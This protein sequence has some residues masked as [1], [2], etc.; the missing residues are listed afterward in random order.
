[1]TFADIGANQGELTLIAA[2]SLSSGTVL[3]FEPMPN[4]FAKLAHNVELNGFSNVR[5][6]NMGLFDSES[7]LPMY[8]KNDS[9]FGAVNEG[10]PSLFS[11]GSDRKEVSVPLRRFD[12]VAR[13]SGLTRLDVMKIDVEGAEMMALRGAEGSIRQFRPVIIIEISEVN[14]RNAGYS[15][16]DLVV[17]LKSL[18]YDIRSLDDRTG[19]LASQCDAVCFPH[20]RAGKHSE[21]R[22]GSPPVPAL[23]V[24]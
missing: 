7:S 17:Y 24:D 10:V 2:K 3:A 9:A 19:A 23:Q 1:M 14:F 22:P 15:T 16:H 12:D 6:F 5:L 4:I 8:V 18:E 21:L 11:T 20:A 13:E